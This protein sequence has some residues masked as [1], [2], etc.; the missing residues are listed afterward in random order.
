MTKNVKLIVSRYGLKK[1]FMHYSIKDAA[2][3][4]YNDIETNQA[5]PISIENN[6]KTEWENKGPSSNSYEKLCILGEI[7]NEY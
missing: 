1:E 5:L 3:S 7:S 4:A 6:G 2:I